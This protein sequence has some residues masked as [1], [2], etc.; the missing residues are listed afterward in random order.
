M[1]TAAILATAV[2]GSH[3]ADSGAPPRRLLDPATLAPLKGSPGFRTRTRRFDLSPDRKRVAVLGGSN[4]R[5]YGLRSRKLQA[6]VDVG[7]LGELTWV[8]RD[9]ILAT[10]CVAMR[11]NLTT[12]DAARG[13]VIRRTPLR[14]SRYP[15]T[16]R[17]GGRWLLVVQPKRTPGLTILVVD[18]N[19]GIR[20]RIRLTRTSPVVA[21]A[22]WNLS[23]NLVVDD[24][25]S[26]VYAL[27]VARG[28]L[29]TLDVP[30][31]F[32]LE[33]KLADGR[34]VITVR[35]G[36]GYER[37]P[38][39]ADTLVV[40]ETL[41]ESQNPYDLKVNPQGFLYQSGDPE[42]GPPADVVFRQYGFDRAQSWERTFPDVYG[43]EAAVIGDYAYVATHSPSDV[44]RTYVL[45]LATG[46]D[47]RA[48]VGSSTVYGRGDSGEF[49]GLRSSNPS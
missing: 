28:T 27:D 18:R 12:V 17:V 26:R 49:H 15:W 19:G 22:V 10:G 38:I 8:A 7:H 30:G 25:N 37:R 24:R 32:R 20:H 21:D 14:T 3:W 48:R 13:R 16:E 5:I 9:R 47:I 2:L 41:A 29:R 11:C 31:L 6:R 23:G 33:G 4:L 1:L 43:I 44:P 35:T 36:A 34:H 40:G 42:F 39:D 46:E 45:D